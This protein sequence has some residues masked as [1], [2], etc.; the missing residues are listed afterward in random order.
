MIRRIDAIKKIMDS[1][2]DEVVIS[3]T[4]MISREVYKVKDRSRNFYVLGSMG[5]AL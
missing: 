2:T 4:G 3:S 1:V 5:S